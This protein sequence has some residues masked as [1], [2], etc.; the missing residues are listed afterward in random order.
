MRRT[1]TMTTIAAAVTMALGLTACGGGDDEPE[2]DN[3]E[4]TNSTSEQTDQG[5]ESNGAD[6]TAEGAGGGDLEEWIA[7]AEQVAA[8]EMS[9]V[10]LSLL[11]EDTLSLVSEFVTDDIREVEAAPYSTRGDGIECVFRNEGEVGRGS[12]EIQYRWA[13]PE[14]GWTCADPDTV[15]DKEVD[16]S[17]GGLTELDVKANE[18]E[19]RSFELCLEDEELWRVVDVRVR[20][21]RPDRA[22]NPDLV[23]EVGFARDVAVTAQ[24]HIEQHHDEWVAALEALNDPSGQNAST[25]GDDSNSESNNDDVAASVS[26]SADQAWLAL[27]EEYSVSEDSLQCLDILDEQVLDFA[28]A[29]T[30]P[31][32]TMLS[33]GFGDGGLACSFGSSMDAGNA[34][35]HIVHERADEEN[36][37]WRCEYSTAGNYEEDS[38]TGGSFMY[39][40]DGN[41][42][43]RHKALCDDEREWSLAIEADIGSIDEHHAPEVISEPEFLD[44]FFDHLLTTEE[45]WTPV[46]EKAIAEAA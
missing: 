30:G 28:A 2:T 12:L 16:E 9:A 3:A 15:E 35:L 24:N 5:A 6:N 46:W 38:L 42:Q 23:R 44:A 45:E 21:I 43:T 11:D 31:E 4:A 39:S 7:A 33:G 20:N 32:L 41:Y 25:F 36:S 40:N 29:F 27:A 26:G 34:T 1:T 14:L 17:T 19:T 22:P 37:Y 8:T 18:N 10:C 13:A